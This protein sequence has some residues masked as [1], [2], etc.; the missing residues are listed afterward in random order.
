MFHLGCNVYLWSGARPLGLLRTV[1][2]MVTGELAPAGGRFFF[3]YFDARGPHYFFLF[4]APGPLD[5]AAIA[6]RLEAAVATEALAADLP[7]ELIEARHRACLGKAMCSADEGDELVPHGS[8]VLFDQTENRYPF[9][10]TRDNPEA[11]RF[12]QLFSELSLLGIELSLEAGGK[13]TGLALEWMAAIADWVD[14]QGLADEYWRYHLS[15]LMLG[16][17]DRFT[18]DDL[19]E[20]LVRGLEAK[21]GQR[22]RDNFGRAFALPGRRDFTP[23]LPEICRLAVLGG[24]RRALATLREVQHAFLKQLGVMPASQLPIL[25]YCW[26]RQRDK[27]QVAP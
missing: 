27:A 26:L 23:L 16:L 14:G 24:G 17:A 9:F 12:W 10:L 3:D 25:L 6:G 21:I 2:D 4:S 20:C 19:E 1:R 7:L 13:P 18:Q 11:G 15:T 5:S 8:V 22:N